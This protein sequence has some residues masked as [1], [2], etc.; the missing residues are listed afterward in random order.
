MKHKQ[1]AYINYVGNKLKE[2]PIIFDDPDVV[3]HFGA[4]DI[5]SEPFAGSCIFSIVYGSMFKNCVFVVS[6]LDTRLI[7]LHRAI[8]NNELNENDYNNAIYHIIFFVTAIYTLA[9]MLIAIPPQE[10][11]AKKH[12]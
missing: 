3:K 8:K 12:K 11:R 6:D 2:I 9:N 7:E 1:R 4:Y 10:K 5:V